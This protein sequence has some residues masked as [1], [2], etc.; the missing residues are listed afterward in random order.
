MTNSN[1]AGIFNVALSK[2][3]T[4]EALEYLLEYLPAYHQAQENR[5]HIDLLELQHGVN[6]LFWFCLLG[7]ADLLREALKKWKY[8]QWVF[9]ENAQYDPFD[10]S[11]KHGD[12]DLKEVW[13]DYFLEDEDNH[14]LV[15]NDYE[16]LRLHFM[17]SKVEKL[18]RLGTLLLKGASCIAKDIHGA[19]L[20]SL[21][22]KVGF[23]SAQSD[24]PVVDSITKEQL[25][26]QEDH[27]QV[28]IE[29]L[30]ETTH[31]PLPTNLSQL[32]E[33]IATLK[34][35]TSENKLLLRP[36]ILTLYH[37]Y[38][39]YFYIYS[40]L[41]II[42]KV[43]FFAIVIFQNTDP[44]SLAFFYTITIALWIFEMVQIY[45]EGLNYFSGIFNC[46]D[47]LIYPISLGLT[48][49]VTVNGF[50]F[51]NKERQNFFVVLVL[52][53]SLVRGVSMLR[54]L[55]S[56]RYLIL[57]LLRVYIDMTPFFVLLLLYIIGNG[58]ILIMINLT[59]DEQILNWRELKK[60]SDIVYNWGYGNWDDPNEMNDLTFLFYLHTGLFIGLVMFNLLIAIISGT[61]EQF[62]EDREIVD[63]EDILSMMDAMAGF[64]NVLR[65]IKEMVFGA[66]EIKMVYYHFLVPREDDGDLE[67]IKERQRRAEEVMAEN[68]ETLEERFENLEEHLK[69]QDEKFEKMEKMMTRL[70]EKIE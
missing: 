28:G 39:W 65:K 19:K 56:T 29:V 5:D 58:R 48:Y 12:S 62:A 15:V 68:Q 16:Y 42:G 57:V 23:A 34:K 44:Y 10:Y 51:L 7:S 25:L 38:R 2:P 59:G 55:D 46:F 41:N 52:Y 64:L 3:S 70:L 45:F 9:A 20:F 22:K 30:H 69:K 40:I 11:L 60:S 1:Y 21:N 53:L 6:P 35:M 27:L 8:E 43:F 17:D 54:V 18:Q 37:K 24:Y 32:S 63:I 61:Y 49:Y 26:K 13:A 4:N 67:E 14:C 50:E 36:L 66:A 33:F 47:F 31:I